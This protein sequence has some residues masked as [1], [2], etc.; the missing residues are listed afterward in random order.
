MY[1]IKTDIKNFRC[2]SRDAVERL[3]RNWVIRPSDS[4]YEEN[5][6]RWRPIGEH[7]DFARC[8]ASLDDAYGNEPNTMAA[9]RTASDA[10]AGYSHNDSSRSMADEHGSYTER[11]H[12]CDQSTNKEI[13]RGKSTIQAGVRG[14][15]NKVKEG[16][17]EIDAS[18]SRAAAGVHR[19]KHRKSRSVVKKLSNAIKRILVATQGSA[20]FRTVAMMHLVIFTWILLPSVIG[21]FDRFLSTEYLHTVHDTWLIGF[22]FIGLTWPIAHILLSRPIARQLFAP[23]Q[24]PT[25]LWESI[26]LIKPKV[27][28]V[29]LITLLV[30]LVIGVGS[31]LFLL[32]GLVAALLLGRAPYLMATRDISFVD[33]LETSVRHSR[34]HLRTI[35]VSM[36]FVVTV[37]VGLA[38]IWISVLVITSIF[39]HNVVVGLIAITIFASSF[40]LAG[41]VTFLINIGTFVRIDEC[42]CGMEIQYTSY[43]SKG[44]IS[45]GQ[46]E[47]VENKL[48]GSVFR[49][50]LKSTVWAGGRATLVLLV[51]IG[52]VVGI[53]WGSGEYL[54]YRE[55]QQLRNEIHELITSTPNTE[56]V[57]ALGDMIGSEFFE[58]EWEDVSKSRRAQWKAF[59]DDHM[60]ELYAHVD[61]AQEFCF[62]LIQFN[63]AGLRPENYLEIAERCSAAD[64]AR[65]RLN[66]AQSNYDR[67][68]EDRESALEKQQQ[69]KEN[70]ETARMMIEM[71]QE[72][73]F[74]LRGYNWGFLSQGPA[75]G[76][77]YY[78]VSEVI[79]NERSQHR[80][81]LM[82]PASEPFQTGYFSMVVSEYGTDRVILRDGR[83]AT[84]P[85][86]RKDYLA[87]ESL[88]V[89]RELLEES[90]RELQTIEIPSSPS[91]RPVIVA[92]S[93]LKQAED[94]LEAYLQKEL[95][96]PEETSGV[97]AEETWNASSTSPGEEPS[98]TV[99]EPLTES[100]KDNNNQ[101]STTE[102]REDRSR[103]PSN[104]G[105]ISVHHLDP[106][107]L[108]LVENA[109]R[110]LDD[111]VCDLQHRHGS[112]EQWLIQAGAEP[113]NFP[114]DEGQEITYRVSVNGSRF[115]QELRV[116]YAASGY[117]HEILCESFALG[118]LDSASDWANRVLNLV[119]STSGYVEVTDN[120]EMRGPEILVDLKGIEG[121]NVYWSDSGHLRT[122]FRP[123]PRLQ[124]QLRVTSA[125]IDEFAKH[126]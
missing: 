16:K 91:R 111:G 23:T 81:I 26:A 93:E 124:E 9:I 82:L 44:T 53:L 78:E 40:S 36:A 61:D 77:L 39:A 106:Y 48:D 105:A 100:G 90:Q 125:V 70:V 88:A 62:L 34:R 54:D 69:A 85:R 52:I 96:A 25:S 57:I 13:G 8:F 116:V 65:S 50:L 120:Q 18:S 6:G 73:S 94:S 110:C 32:P 86:L 102:T 31:V 119:S 113:T 12:E 66:I 55:E 71:H 19:D 14:Q 76:L 41:F 117:I 27:V 95:G 83:A 3:I 74:E 4:I 75:E 46:S 51:I 5:V 122:I 114:W 79:F 7:P 33:A 72:N 45:A 80:F 37:G 63:S 28:P 97:P 15:P 98:P 109:Q 108:S 89:A 107:V 1:R 87:A 68:K 118:N 38:A 58:S 24:A 123:T 101:T 115:C 84:W 104:D 60:M 67:R 17:E 10:G 11:V 47:S 2:E 59:L 29:S 22:A 99:T 112:L 56:H 121:V 103:S 49:D 126:H 35:G 30:F 42:E 21:I 20:A 92:R 64:N 43:A